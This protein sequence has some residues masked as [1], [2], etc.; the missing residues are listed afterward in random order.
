MTTNPRIKLR[1]YAYDL[2][3]DKKVCYQQLNNEEKSIMTSLII[4]T[5]DVSAAWEFISE[6]DKQ[7]ELPFLLSKYMNGFKVEDEE[8]IIKKMSENACNYASKRIDEVLE[9]M[10]EQINLDK[11]YFF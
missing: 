3:L 8:N 1:S 11:K 4:N 5:C 2:A 9:D 7:N 6:S 10:V